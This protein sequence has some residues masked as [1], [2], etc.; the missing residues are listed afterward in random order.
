M[1]RRSLLLT[2]LLAVGLVAVVV[3]RGVPAVPDGVRR[4]PDLAYGEDPAQRLDVY[5]PVATGGDRPLILMVHGGGWRRGDKQNGR[6]V[7][8]KVAH[9][10][11]A[12]TVL[13]S[14]DYRM[15]PQRD[16]LAQVEDVA[17]ALAYVQAHA[18]QWGADPQRVV[19]MGHSAGAHLVA[20]LSA[21]PAQARA[22]GAARWLGTVALDSA[23]LDVP[24]VMERR[25]M[26]LYDAAFGDEPARWRA[27]SPRHRLQASAVP[28]L[29]VCSSTRPD[30]P[31]EQARA[32][33]AR[34]SAL[35]VRAEVL[36]LALD[37]AG[38]NIQLGLP[39]TFT[40]AVDAFLAGIGA[41]PNRR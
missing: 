1:V 34:A 12:G 37:H 31:C 41:A 9:W 13:V 25:H 19:L 2:L 18:R 38:I 33:A 28:L 15:L 17:R 39:G 21:D 23:A 10:V 30:R 32:Y 6:V 8:N 5:L 3:A 14:I 22:F 26:G 7:D 11:P 20:L 4:L 27:A 35:G 36:P 40:S 24:A 16:A 29:A